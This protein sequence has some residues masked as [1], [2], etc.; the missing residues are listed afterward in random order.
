MTVSGGTGTARSAGIGTESSPIV[1][2][3]VTNR[4]RTLAAPTM[5][6]PTLKDRRILGI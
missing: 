2:L 5:V 1:N 3:T 6:N 4:A